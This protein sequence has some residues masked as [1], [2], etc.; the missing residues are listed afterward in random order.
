[1]KATL[2]LNN[3]T[4][5]VILKARD[6]R[7]HTE[8]GLLYLC[9]HHSSS[10]MYFCQQADIKSIT[11]TGK[12]KGPK[13]PHA[14]T[15]PAQTLTLDIG[16]D[17]SKALIEELEKLSNDPESTLIPMLIDQITPHFEEALSLIVAKQ[18]ESF[19]ENR[20]DTQFCNWRQQLANLNDNMES[21][22]KELAPPTIVNSLAPS[23]STPPTLHPAEPVPPTPDWGNEKPADPRPTSAQYVAHEAVESQVGTSNAPAPFPEHL[24]VATHQRIRSNPR[25]VCRHCGEFN[26]HKATCKYVQSGDCEAS[27]PVA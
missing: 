14:R 27:A 4:D 10:P 25:Q 24:T 9:D 6:I 21:L 12:P 3:C 18:L 26:F 23:I 8:Q 19:Y 7:V 2:L 20:I 11:I 16:A 17:I 5:P 22:A 13:I 1:M 15:S